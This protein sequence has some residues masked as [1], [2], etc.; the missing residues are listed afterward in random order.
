MQDIDSTFNVSAAHVA[1]SEIDSIRR[2]TNRRLQVNTF[3]DDSLPVNIKCWKWAVLFTVFIVNRSTNHKH[4]LFHLFIESFSGN[5]L[6]VCLMISLILYSYNSIIKVD[7]SPTSSQ[8]PD[9]LI[10]GLLKKVLVENKF[11][12][13]QRRSY[14]A[15]QERVP[16]DTGKGTLLYEVRERLYKIVAG[17]LFLNTHGTKLC[18]CIKT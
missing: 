9:F 7:C 4:L 5:V 2:N 18:T 13:F 15:V 14:W 11:V 6:S 1:V 17:K 12:S 8:N 3:T 10:F 16:K